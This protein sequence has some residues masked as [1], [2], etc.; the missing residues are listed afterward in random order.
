MRE[1][2]QA[3]LDGT[4][5]PDDIAILYHVG[6]EFSGETD[7]RLH[8]DGVFSLWS[9]VTAGRTR[10]DYTGRVDQKQVGDVARALLHGQVWNVQHVRAISGDDDPEV[11]IAVQNGDRVTEVILWVSEVNHRPAFAE[12]QRSL[13]E[14]IREVSR[15]E[16]L[17][18]GR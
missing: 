12:A 14:L 4:L 11:R 5:S 18:V 3:Y 7:F 8:G 15:G 2:L 17:E 16:V 1:W 9:T 13:I 10:R 6:D